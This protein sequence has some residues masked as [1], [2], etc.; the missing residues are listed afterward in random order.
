MAACTKADWGIPPSAEELAA[1]DRAKCTEYG[2]PPE[3]PERGVCRMLLDQQ[4]AQNEA[5]IAA[6]RAQNFGTPL[7]GAILLNQAIQPR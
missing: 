4:R 7:A 6:A 1:M 2:Y 3:H 5:A